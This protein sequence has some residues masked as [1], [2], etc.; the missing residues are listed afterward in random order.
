M[1]IAKKCLAMSG[2]FEAELLIELMLRY[3]KHPLAPDKEFR[4]GLLEGA[5]EVLRSCLAGQQAIEDIP[6]A[7]MNLVAATWYVEWNAVSNGAEDPQGK[8]Q[9]WLDGVR[10]AIPSCFC[11]PDSLP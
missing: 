2:L 9:M 10:K 5:A 4:N 8:R 7:D 11:P 6:P 3:W 1:S